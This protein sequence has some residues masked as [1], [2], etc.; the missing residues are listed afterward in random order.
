MEGVLGLIVGILIAALISGFV[1]WIVSMLNLG[2]SV[3]NFGWAMLAGLL[4]GILTNL[5]QSFVGDAGGII[6]IVINLVI[7]ALVILGCG[8]LLKGLTVNGFVGALIAAVAIALINW[9][10]VILLASA[11]GAMA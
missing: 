2:L 8:A 5:A 1:L 7:A 11:G 6:G 10:L 4:I 9:G 3:A